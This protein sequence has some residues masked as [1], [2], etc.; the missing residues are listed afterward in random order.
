MSYEQK[1]I[2]YEGK[3]LLAEEAKTI[4][5]SYEY[6][7]AI[8]CCDSMKEAKDKALT[9]ATEQETAVLAFGSL[10]YLGELKNV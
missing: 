6:N 10:S 2:E 4:T 5:D 7:V 3:A 8:E 9:Y 1:R